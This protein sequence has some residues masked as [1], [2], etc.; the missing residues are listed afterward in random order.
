VVFEWVHDHAPIAVLVE[1]LNR[2]I[3]QVMRR[4]KLMSLFVGLLCPVTGVLRYVNCGHSF[5]LYC[6]VDGSISELKYVNFPLGSTERVRNVQEQEL[7]LAPGAWLVLYTDGI[8]EAHS[9]DHHQFGYDRLREGIAAHRSAPATAMKAALLEELQVF[10]GRHQVDDD[11]TLILIRRE[12]H[13][14][15]VRP[16]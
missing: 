5:P 3:F 6:T 11:V 12:V 16:S 13:H 7:Q 9:P 8:I 2:T 10:T 4:K 1:R 15:A 14:D